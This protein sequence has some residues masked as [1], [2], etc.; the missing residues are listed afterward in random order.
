MQKSSKNIYKWVLSLAAP[1]ALQNIITMSV[2]LADNLM[3]GSLGELPLSA[4]Y[5][6][7]QLQNILHMLIIG[8]TAALI[9][10]ASQYWGKR[11]TDSVKMLIGIALKFS[12]SA[13]LLFLLITLFF[14][15]QVIRLFTNEPHVIPEAVKHLEILRYSYIFFC[16][17]QVLVAAMRCVETVRVGMYLSIVTFFVNVFLNW[18]LIFG[19]LGA[20]A[21]GGN[22]AAIATVIARILETVLIILYIRFVD[23]KLRIRI[24]DLIKSNITLVK[25]FFRYGFPVIL[26]DIFWGINLATQGAIIGRLGSVATASVSIANTVFSLFSIGVYGTAGASSVIIGQT[27][28][29]GEYERVKKYARKLQVLFIII[30]LISGGLLYIARDYI[31]LLYNVS[32][33]TAVLA[34]KLM[35]VLSVT[36][37]GT[38]Y[39]M[40][41]LTGIVRAGGSVYFVLINDLIFV[42]LIVIPSA[43]IAAFVLHASPVVV[44]ACLKCDQILKCAVAVVKVNRFKW[45][46]NLTREPAT[47]VK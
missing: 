40:S 43:M 27:V 39:Q 5:V 28:G 30:G 33:D 1:I 37:I 46:K 42:W 24:K 32:E 19:K 10:L 29:A 45:I 23:R 16:V 17:T 15:E 7:H 3:V 36:M 12:M 34:K 21:L 26:G 9:I 38:S 13:G 44:F 14:P 4:M 2:N 11:D 20:P 6:A 35:T 31:M 18:V 22:G 41:S 47:A 25:D 8:L